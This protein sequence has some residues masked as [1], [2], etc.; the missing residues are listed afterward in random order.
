MTPSKQIEELIGRLEKATGPD[1][2]LD[3][4]IAIQT[5]WKI[6]DD[7][8]FSD[9]AKQYPK[10]ARKDNFPYYTSSIDAAL[11]LV[12]EGFRWRVERY[13]IDE[14]KCRAELAEVGQIINAGMDYGIGIKCRAQTSASTPALALCIA[15]LRA[16]LAILSKEEA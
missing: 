6:A 2:E 14:T 16:R 4:D 11:T 9:Y 7:C 1:R 10:L 5:G 13:N 12:L 8:A 15:S 3:F